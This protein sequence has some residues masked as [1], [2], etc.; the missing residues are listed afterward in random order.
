MMEKNATRILDQ[1]AAMVRQSGRGRLLVVKGPDR[2]ETITI[3][4]L[5]MTVRVVVTATQG[6]QKASASSA[7]SA[8]VQPAP[9]PVATTLPSLSGRAVVG[10]TVVLLGVAAGGWRAVLDA[11]V[12][13]SE[14]FG[15][16]HGDHG[17][18]TRGEDEFQS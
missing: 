8:P 14:V 2:G 18:G 1:G 13:E 6:L 10:A 15:E 3:S 17:H 16:R 4:D 11:V 7:L 9:G 5:A 12:D